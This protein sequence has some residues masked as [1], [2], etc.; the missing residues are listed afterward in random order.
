MSLDD[1]LR[2]ELSDLIVAYTSGVAGEDQFARLE[3]I[4]GAS[5]E[6]V[7]FY[8]EMLDVHANLY[9]YRPHRDEDLASPLDDIRS[10]SSGEDDS[11]IGDIT[12]EVAPPPLPL[13]LPP[14]N[15]LSSV[16][17]GTIAFFSQ[18]LP[19]ALLIATAVTGLGLLIGSMVYVSRPEQIAGKPTPSGHPS[20]RS[21]DNSSLAV[22][23]KITGLADC[24]WSAKCRVPAGYDNILI[25]RQFKLDSG[26]VEITYNSGAKVILQGPCSYEVNSRD[27]GFLQIGKLTARLEKSGEGSRESK[28]SGKVASGQWPVASKEGSGFRG[29]GAGKVAS[30]TNLPSPASGRGGGGEGGQPLEKAF[31]GQWLVTGETNP[32]IPKS[33]I[34]NPSFSPA[35]AFVVRTP[36]ATVTDLG[37]EFGVEVDRAGV[38]STHVYR[39]VVELQPTS[40]DDQ[41]E[42]QTVRLIANE[43]AQV[44]KEDS[45]RRLVVRRTPVDAKSFVRQFVQSP[46]ILDI[47]DIVAGGDGLGHERERGIDP[48][49][50]MEE[51]IFLSHPRIND[52]KYHRATYYKYVDGTFIPDGSRGPVQTDSAGHTFDFPKTLGL[53]MGPIWARSF[54]PSEK[55]EKDANYWIHSGDFGY[56]LMPQ[57]RGLLGMHANVGITFDLDALRKKHQR[58]IIRFE[59]V[60]GKTPKLQADCWVLV[61]GQV[62]WKATE[63]K[64]STWLVKVEIKPGDR[65]LTVAATD[66]GQ[67]Q[68]GA[69]WTVLGD[70]VLRTVATEMEQEEN[71]TEK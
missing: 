8:I 24:R 22:V 63:L 71:S 31:R 68:I 45:G 39:G 4:L 56:G 25:G 3:K 7:N 20:L 10:N 6:A 29:Q 62:R 2:Q 1:T 18:E 19:F 12:V 48:S 36:S 70:P 42:G 5:E 11:E 66:G 21:T 34:Q 65:F 28:R 41:P 23:A 64:G 49:C 47:L 37:T 17:H 69:M 57:R 46:A 16:F 14:A 52:G 50:S 27:G 30:E 59:A 67:K 38:T 40:D 55:L 44:V 58:A 26:L 15:V 33:Q 35:P 54:K 53:T 60:A 61:D 51:P 43:S 32:E 9:W 13:T